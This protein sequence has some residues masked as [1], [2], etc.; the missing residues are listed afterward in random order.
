MCCICPCIDAPVSTAFPRVFDAPICP[1]IWC[2]KK[3]YLLG[4]EFHMNQK[5]QENWSGLGRGGRVLQLSATHT[6]VNTMVY[7]IRRA[8]VQ[9]LRMKVKKKSPMSELYR[10]TVSKCVNMFVTTVLATIVI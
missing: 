8:Q 7:V 9:I 6:R 5:N 4:Y 3:G 1:E 2:E 10:C